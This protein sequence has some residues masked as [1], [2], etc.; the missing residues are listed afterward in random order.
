MLL[1][2]IPF[3][4]APAELSTLQTLIDEVT[5]GK[6]VHDGDMTLELPRVADNGNSVALKVTVDS[7]MSA[8]AYVKSIHLFA[9]ANPRPVMARYY[10]TPRSGRAEINTRIRLAATQEVTA[11]AAMSDNSFRKTT[12]KVIVAM[13]ACLDGS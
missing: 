8:D 6:P 3:K 11:L 2:L 12:A 1:P 13:A 9:P 7:P 5:G 4:P 10:L